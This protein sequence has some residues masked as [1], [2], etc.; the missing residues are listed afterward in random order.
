MKSTLLTLSIVFSFTLSWSQQADTTELKE[1]VVSSQR[2]RTTFKNTARHVTLISRQEIE[3]AP[4]QSIAELLE[5]AASVDIRQRGQFGVQADVS[6]RGGSFDQTLILLNGIK[7]TDPQTGHHSMNLPVD[8]NQIERIEVLQGGGSRIFGPNAFAGAINIITKKDAPNQVTVG[9]LAG[10]YGLFEGRAAAT[11]NTGKWNHSLAYTRRSSEGFTQNTDFNWENL[12]FQT[13]AQLNKHQLTANLGWNRKAFGAS[14]F[15]SGNFPFQFEATETQ[16]ASLIDQID[17]AERFKITVKGYY[18]RHFDRFELFRE[19]P[20]YF[21]RINDTLFVMEGDTVP[22][23]YRGHNYHRTD[24]WG[25]EFNAA[26]TSSWGTT[27]LGAD[28]RKEEIRS[29]ALGEPVSNPERVSNEHPSALYT[30]FED[31]TNISLYAEHAAQ[32]KKWMISGGILY[33]LNTDFED[34]IFPGL[35]IAYQLHPKL[36][37]YAS[38]NRSVRFPT[39]TDLYYN[40]GGAVGSKNLTPEESINYEVG[41]KFFTPKITGNLALFRREGTN[42]IDWI[43]PNGSQVTRAANITTVN[44]N[45][46]EIDATVPLSKWLDK[47]I[48]KQLR[49]SYTYLRADTT[50]RDFESNYV[51]DFLQHKFNLNLVQQV[52]DQIT[53]HWSASYQDRLGGYFNTTLGREVSFDPVLLVDARIAHQGDKFKLFLEVANLLNADYAD[54]GNVPQPGRWLRMGLVFNAP[55]GKQP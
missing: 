53:I 4:V 35:D 55:F 21:N 33:N 18:R 5:Y 16:F 39:Y 43:R 27:S 17:V 32:F 38:A 30:R 10:E 14:T 2:A 40:Q 37:L 24:S 9:A 36:R 8:L 42:L 1:V 45:G 47:S 22:T 48:F 19:D 13:A 51:L 46:A 34:E 7:M 50:S 26:Y 3:S 12:F 31:R 28:Y 6:I 54:I 25:A 49:F 15:Y 52:S 20:G 41:T 29:N 11:L 44:V 23:W